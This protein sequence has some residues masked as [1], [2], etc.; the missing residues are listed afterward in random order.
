MGDLERESEERENNLGQYLSIMVPN[1][2]DDDEIRSAVKSIAS[3]DFLEF[4]VEM[5][6]MFEYSR[7]R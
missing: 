6:E 5:A 3:T 4:E 1:E 7:E 2:E